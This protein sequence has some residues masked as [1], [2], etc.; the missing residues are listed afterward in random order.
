M[1]K[2]N[3]IYLIYGALTTSGIMIIGWI[4]YLKKPVIKRLTKFIEGTNY[5]PDPKN[6]ELFNDLKEL[7]DKM[8]AI[9]IKDHPAKSEILRIFLNCVVLSLIKVLRNIINDEENYKLHKNKVLI[10]FLNAISNSVDDFE[11]TFQLE[12]TKRG[13]EIRDIDSVFIATSDHR[14]YSRESLKQTVK[15][16][17]RK[18]KD[19]P[20]IFD[21]ILD[22]IQPVLKPL[23][24]IYLLIF[25]QLNGEFDKYGIKYNSKNE[26]EFIKL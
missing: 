21:N 4:K 16:A 17:F 12:M 10:K 22:S 2:E 26:K 24:H 3:N 19:V 11:E 23:L 5:I 20:L 15:K 9:A 7:R 8:G 13:L 18:G 1:I 25:I 6:H 14:D